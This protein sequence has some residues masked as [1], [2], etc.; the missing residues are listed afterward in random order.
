MNRMAFDAITEG[1][2]VWDKDVKRYVESTFVGDYN[3]ISESSHH[4]S[5]MDGID[6]NRELA[7]RVPTANQKWPEYF[8]T[9]LL[10]MVSQWTGMH[11]IHGNAMVPLLIGAQG[12]MEQIA[13]SAVLLPRNSG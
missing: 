7:Q 9:W 11:R 4:P 13:P 8:H 1:I 10:A 2:T 6:P 5:C 12:G 3:P